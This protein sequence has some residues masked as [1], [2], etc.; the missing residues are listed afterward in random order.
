MARAWESQELQESKSAAV[1]STPPSEVGVGIMVSEEMGRVRLLVLVCVVA[2]A[3]WRCGRSRKARYIW[4]VKRRGMLAG[5]IQR[6]K[7]I[8]ESDFAPYQH[9]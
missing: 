4:V 2:L 5:V 1:C 6:V 9:I 8:K 3:D 7:G